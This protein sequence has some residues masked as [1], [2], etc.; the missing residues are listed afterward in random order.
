MTS[1]RGGGIGA[2]VRLGFGPQVHD[3]LGV[4]VRQPLQSSAARSRGELFVYTTKQ[5][6]LSGCGERPLSVVLRPLRS[7]GRV[8]APGRLRTL[9]PPLTLSR[10]VGKLAGG[11][12][13]ES[14]KFVT[15]YLLKQH[16][17]FYDLNAGR[18]LGTNP[19]RRIAP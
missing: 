15:K 10:I 17:W 5:C 1:R 6:D 18:I 12:V 19:G 7:G 3:L 13:G 8:S 11:E 14:W 2:P 16:H 4:D 9:P